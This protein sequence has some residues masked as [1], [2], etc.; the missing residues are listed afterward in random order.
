MSINVISQNVMCWEK[1]ELGTYKIRRPLLKRVFNNYDADIIGMQEVTERWEKYFDNDLKNFDKL[2]VYR[3][4]SSKEAVPIYWNK[5]KLTV[6]D[7]GYFWLSETPEVS[8]S[9]WNSG[10]VRIT[11]WVLFK[12]KESGK[13]FAFVNTHLD[14]ASELARINGIKLIDSFI[15]NKFGSDIPLVLTG[16]FN[17][18]PNSETIKTANNFLNDTRHIASKTTTDLT[19]HAY[20]PDANVIIDYIFV[21]KN[22]KCSEFK[23]IK[24]LDDKGRPQSDH[25]GVFAKLD[26]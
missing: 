18:S 1:E 3:S 13:V 14:H 19:F 2:L 11:C 25:F 7:S 20:Q 21:S 8:S 15:K 10:C 12:I 4:E 6:V 26:L 5:N 9:S 16:D 24:E 22:I 23:I 17:S